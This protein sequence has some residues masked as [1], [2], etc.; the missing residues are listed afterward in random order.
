[1]A[2]GAKLF[3]SKEC[4]AEDCAKQIHKIDN[5]ILTLKTFHKLFSQ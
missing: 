5:E 3:V 1:M 4:N 2:W